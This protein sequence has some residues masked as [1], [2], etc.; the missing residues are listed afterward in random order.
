MHTTIEEGR[1]AGLHSNP[2]EEFA[3]RLFIAAA[4]SVLIGY[5]FY[6]SLVFNFHNSTFQ[7]ITLGFIASAFYMLLVLISK[8]N[9]I[10]A[11]IVICLLAQA[12]IPKPFTLAYIARDVSYFITTGIA[13]YY[14]WKSPFSGAHARVTRP[15]QLAGYLSISGIVDT[16]LLS[17]INNSWQHFGSNLYWKCSLLCLIGVGIGIGL[18][19]GEKVYRF[20]FEHNHKIPG[21]ESGE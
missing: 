1:P 8:R 7:F 9:A 18:E 17:V 15:L 21:A 13:V 11:Y 4:G 10:A 6:P 5:I 16:I 20:Y 3:I 2:V 14:Y 12:V 19:A